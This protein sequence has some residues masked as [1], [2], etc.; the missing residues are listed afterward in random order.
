MRRSWPSFVRV[1]ERINS[2]DASAISRKPPSYTYAPF[3]RQVA[4]AHTRMASATTPAARIAFD[5]R[6]AP[7]RGRSANRIARN[8]PT[9]RSSPRVSVP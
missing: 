2:A 7:I 3:W 5:G 6:G 8:A 4:N 9:T 1:S